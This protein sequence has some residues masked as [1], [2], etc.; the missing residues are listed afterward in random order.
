MKFFV[1]RIPIVVAAVFD[2]QTVAGTG[3][4]LLFFSTIAM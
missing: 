3:E 1:Q 2:V 4:A